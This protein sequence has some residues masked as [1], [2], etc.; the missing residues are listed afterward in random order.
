MT[1][2]GVGIL[3]SFEKVSWYYIQAI[4]HL[5]EMLEKSIDL[6]CGIEV[7]TVLQYF[8]AAGNGMKKYLYLLGKALLSIYL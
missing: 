6:L 3:M 5:N 2:H 4:I 8:Q 7:L 1:I